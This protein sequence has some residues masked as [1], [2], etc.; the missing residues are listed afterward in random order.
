MSA[1]PR[2][3]G[4]YRATVLNNL[5]PQ[6]QGRIMVQLGDQYGLFPSTW[7]MPAFPFASIAAG[8]VALPAVASTVWVE[9][10]AGDPDFPI[11]SGAMWTDP[12]GFPPLALAGATPLTPNIHLQTTTGTSITLSDNPAQQVFVKTITG[13][14][15][16][17]GTAGITLMNGQGAS[18]AM[19]GPSVIINGGALVIT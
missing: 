4:K 5:D 8:V 15:I 19:V 10:E 1:G 13:A 7:A 17:V 16:I 2:F 14:V 18:I 12:G 6:L 3:Y 11:W 9:F